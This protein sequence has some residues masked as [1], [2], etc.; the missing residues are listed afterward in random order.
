MPTRMRTPKKDRKSRKV[1]TT[2]YV[3]PEL[4]TRL[5]RICHEVGATPSLL[6]NY[7]LKDLT[8]LTAFKQLTTFK[9]LRQDIQKFK[10]DLE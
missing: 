7:L 8:N 3:T 5:D 6:I 10:W 1:G 4:K 9:R 2:I